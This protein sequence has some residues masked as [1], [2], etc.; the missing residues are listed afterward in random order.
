M[1]QCPGPAAPGDGG[2]PPTRGRGLKPVLGDAPGGPYVAPH[3]GARIETAISWSE[4]RRPSSPPTRGRGLKRGY[5]GAGRDGDRR[6][7]RGG[8]D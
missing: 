2:S 6:P 3:A 4:N 8:A 1:K 5:G 7:P